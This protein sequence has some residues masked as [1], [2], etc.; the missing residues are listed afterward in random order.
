LI[1]LR[2]AAFTKAAAGPRPRRDEDLKVDRNLNTRCSILDAGFHRRAP[3]PAL[4]SEGQSVLT[5]IP[6]FSSGE[7]RS[8]VVGLFPYCPSRWLLEDRLNRRSALFFENFVPPFP[9]KEVTNGN[10]SRGGARKGFLTDHYSLPKHFR[11]ATAGSLNFRP[12]TFEK[13]P[14]HYTDSTDIFL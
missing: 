2:Q 10:T 1:R 8:D 7:W 11:A 14:T 4:D 13:Q 5:K 3:L 12:L 6:Q 9:E